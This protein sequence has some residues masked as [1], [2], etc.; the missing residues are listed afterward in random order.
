MRRFVFLGRS[1]TDDD[2]VLILQD[3]DRLLD[4]VELLLTLSGGL[5]LLASMGWK[6]KSDDTDSK[7][8]LLSDKG[9]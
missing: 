7:E 1:N 8:I 2:F 5:G 6:I 9:A 4:V 3:L